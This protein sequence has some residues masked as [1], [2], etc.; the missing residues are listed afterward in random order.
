MLMDVDISVVMT[1]YNRANLLDK[2]L[3]SFSR[4]TFPKKQ[5]EIVLVDDQST[6]NI[7]EVLQKHKD[8]RIQHIIMDRNKSHYPATSNCPALGLNIGFKQARAEIIY[9]T[10]PEM[11]QVGETQTMLGNP[12]DLIE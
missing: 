10:D 11:Y 5:Y 1:I 4:Q 3:S 7:E 6:D 9:K 12:L 2:T 8:L